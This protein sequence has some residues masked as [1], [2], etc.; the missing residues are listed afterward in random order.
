MA[1]LPRRTRDHVLAKNSRQFLERVLPDEW[2][3]RR[4]EE[5]DYGLDIQVEIVQDENV[6]GAYFTIQLKGTDHIK[7]SK[8]RFVSH[9]CKTSTLNY[10]LAR[11]ELVVYL[12]YDAQTD[13][14]YW[15]W[16]KDYIL[17]NLK[18][19]WQQQT[20][21]TLLIPL[22][23][24]F[25]EQA[26][27]QIEQRVLQEHHTATILART[28]SLNA[29][30]RPFRYSF[31][32]NEEGIEIGVVPKYRRT[33]QE[34]PIIMQGTF[35]FDQSPEGQAAMNAL[36]HAWQTG[37]PATIDGRFIQDLRLPDAFT[38]IFPQTDEFQ[39]TSLQISPAMTNERRQFRLRLLDA[40]EQLLTE[41]PYLDMRVI[42]AGTKEVTYANDQQ[43][44]WLNFRL[45]ISKEHNTGSASLEMRITGCNVVQV[46]QAIRLYRASSQA[47]WVE[48]VDL[49]TE[50]PVR[51]EFAET[52]GKEPDPAMDELIDVL[53]EIQQR[54]KQ[55]ITWPGHITEQEADL[56]HLVHAI[57]KTGQ[58]DE[59]A[60]RGFFSVPKPVA[61]QFIADVL[62]RE[63][64]L[65]FDQPDVTIELLGSTIPLGRVLTVVRIASLAN[66]TLQR[67]D[68]IDILPDDANIKITVN[69]GDPCVRSFFP[70]WHP[71]VPK[72]TE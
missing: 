16:V 49:E 39:W 10:F 62:T 69:I 1:N 19:S 63:Q 29:S 59:T 35:T 2:I 71:D 5:D 36:Q 46:K 41:V 70:R 33:E 53:V 3:I 7:T 72:A 6:I 65:V 51:S 26:T 8:G 58:V 54:T 37:A 24:R 40:A 14:G 30:N 22:D 50:I 25:D 68:E 12:V 42:Q 23:R 20:K 55:P 9:S 67:L 45:C 21:N 56:V 52:M 48:L 31:S 64:L 13:T 43:D 60:K 34:H 61:Q 17:N 38:A 47:H 57:V 66:D 27:Q 15:L 18:S 32:R 4:I 11:P 44:H 28:E